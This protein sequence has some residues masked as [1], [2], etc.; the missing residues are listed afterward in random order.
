M[1][2]LYEKLEANNLLKDGIITL[3][4]YESGC[5]QEVDKETFGGFFGSTDGTYA[6]LVKVG[7]PLG[8]KSFFDDWKA[9]GIL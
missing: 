2:S 5:T 7:T 1:K 4:T 8:Y 6:E 9:K 3:A